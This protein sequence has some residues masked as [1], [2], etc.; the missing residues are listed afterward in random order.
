MIF[1]IYIV[2]VF[3]RKHAII[4]IK[5]CSCGMMTCIEKH[6]QHK[7]VDTSSNTRNVQKREI[8]LSD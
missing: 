5:V 7:I 2:S 6:S 8:N 4:D 3:F 1:D